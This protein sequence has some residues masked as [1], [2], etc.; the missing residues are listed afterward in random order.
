MQRLAGGVL[1]FGTFSL[2]RLVLPDLPALAAAA[3]TAATPLVAVHARI[4]KE[5]IFVAAVLVLALAVLIRLLRDPAPHRAILLGILAGLAA[6]SKYIGQLIVPFTVAAI[7][8]V[9]TPGPQRRM[10][11][12][13]L[14]AAVSAPYFS[15]CS[16]RS[17]GC[18]VGNVA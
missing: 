8:V 4:L 15:S 10:L 17:G 5:D 13:A 12:A 16:R 6:S 11:K 9:P 1:V 7:L 14:V 2:A 3:A 18:I